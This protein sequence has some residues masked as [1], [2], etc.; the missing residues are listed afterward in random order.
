MHAMAVTAN[1]SRHARALGFGLGAVA[2]MIA[3][4]AT[5]LVVFGP[6]ERRPPS[7]RSLEPGPVGAEAA[8]S[9]EPAAAQ[10]DASDAGGEPLLEARPPP[11]DAAPLDPKV[12]KRGFGT[13]TL[14]VEPWAEVYEGRRRLG[15]TPM[16]PFELPIGKHVLTL[17]NSQ[18]GVTRQVT[19]KVTRNAHLTLEVSLAE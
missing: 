16:R 15:L 1:N 4:V 17:K 3:I 10:A 12:R 11:E 6:A 7:A 13:L 18:L 2:A 9:G 5:V 14:K 19:A 8:D